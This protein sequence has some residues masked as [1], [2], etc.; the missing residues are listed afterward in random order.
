MS[1]DGKGTTG[2]S[3]NKTNW[4]NSTNKAPYYGVP[5]TF[6]L[7]FTYDG[8]KVDTASRVLSMNG[9]PIPE[10]YATGELTG[11][12]YHK[13][14]PATFC[15]RYMAFGMEAGMAIAKKLGKV[16]QTNGKH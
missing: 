14:P 9:V 11:L 10:L 5:M 13:D 3:P 1:L 6:H 15:L 4:A 12:V 8:L 2:R 16:V 7:T